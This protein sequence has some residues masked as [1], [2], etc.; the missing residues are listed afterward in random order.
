MT[1]GELESKIRAFI[2]STR[3]QSV[4][5]K[6]NTTW[7]K[8]CSS[9]D[10]IGDTEVAIEAYLNMEESESDGE[11]YLFLYGVLQA[12]F[13]QQDAVKNLAIALSI[14]CP[15]SPE[16]KEIRDIRNISIGH[17]T[18]MKRRKVSLFGFIARY[19]ICKNG[20]ILSKLSSEENGL[21]KFE[22][23]NVI[24]LINSQRT[25][26]SKFL[27]TFLEKLKAEEMEHRKMHREEK[28]GD[29]FHNNL[30]Y[31]F[32]KIYG[33]THSSQ[34]PEA[35]LM[36]T[37]LISE[38]IEK[39]KNAL[40]NRDLFDT[41]DSLKYELEL[42]EYPLSELKGFFNEPQSSKLNEKDAYIFASFIEE[43]IGKIKKTAEEIDQEYNSEL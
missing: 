6:D 37:N 25:E 32:E 11:K 9:L 20:F 19:S 22:E 8:L 35:G 21:P 7:G 15:H 2:N 42:L 33:A 13:I 17:P 29:F 4:L 18:E 36:H 43:Y 34:P 31:Y 14:E 16:L 5:L 28:L 23:I 12:L 27:N 41:Y 40:K 38:V 24:E 10:V 39:F 1:V 3:L 30:S 26:H